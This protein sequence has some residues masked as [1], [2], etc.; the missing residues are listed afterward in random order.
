MAFQKVL[1]RAH[2]SMKLILGTKVQSRETF[3]GSDNVMNLEKWRQLS[4]QNLG[5][6]LSPYADEAW[7]HL[8]Y[9]DIIGK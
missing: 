7:G 2:G 6:N 8:V 9:K 5:Q 4:Q 1:D 3:K